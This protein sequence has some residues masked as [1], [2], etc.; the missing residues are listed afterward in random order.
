MMDVAFDLIESLKSFNDGEIRAYTR[1]AT[2][3]RDQRLAEGSPAEVAFWNSVVSLCQDERQRRTT[4]IRRLEAMYQTGV[5][6]AKA[7]QG[8]SEFPEE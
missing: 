6:P 7:N 3:W 8:Y 4:E 2:E 5:D 1:F